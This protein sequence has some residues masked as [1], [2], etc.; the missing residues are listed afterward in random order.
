[1][2]LWRIFRIP[3][4]IAAVTLVGLLSALLGDGPWDALSWAALALP[5]A[6]IAWFWLRPAR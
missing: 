4:L 2:T 3:L 6:V 1:M 5:L